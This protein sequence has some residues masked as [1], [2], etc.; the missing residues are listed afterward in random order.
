MP[1]MISYASFEPLKPMATGLHARAP[2]LTAPAR[3][4][5]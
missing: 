5:H 4:N 1:T 2:W 3:V